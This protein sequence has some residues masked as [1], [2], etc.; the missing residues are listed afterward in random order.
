MNLCRLNRVPKV[1]AGAVV[2]ADMGSSFILDVETR[3]VD[4]AGGGQAPLRITTDN[5]PS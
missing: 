3:Q 1:L 2:V 4:S 5:G